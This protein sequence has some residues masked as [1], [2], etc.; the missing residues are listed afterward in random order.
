MVW[1]GSSTCAEMGQCAHTPCSLLT[2]FPLAGSSSFRALLLQLAWLRLATLMRFSKPWRTSARLIPPM[3]HLQKAAARYYFR[4]VVH[5]Q[6]SG[7]GRCS[8][9]CIF[10]S[11]LYSSTTKYFV[12]IKQ[13]LFPSINMEVMSFSW[14]WLCCT[15]AKTSLPVTVRAYCS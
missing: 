10:L 7:E 12:E 9:Y 3:K 11:F 13:F 4:K 6:G 1:F 14:T 2:L 8:W 5:C 15:S